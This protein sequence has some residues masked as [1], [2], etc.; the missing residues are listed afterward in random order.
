MY[1]KN[2]SAYIH[3]CNTYHKHLRMLNQEIIKIN[4]LSFPWFQ[5]ADAFCLGW[6]F[7]VLQEASQDLS[8]FN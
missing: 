3:V 4:Y 2:A 7:H 5:I 8:P 1:N 6:Q